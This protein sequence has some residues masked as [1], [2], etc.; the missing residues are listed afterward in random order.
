MAKR[1]RDRAVR[2]LEPVREPLVVVGL[3]AAGSSGRARGRRR[4]CAAEARPAP[5]GPPRASRAAPSERRRGSRCSG[6]TRGRETAPRARGRA[7]AGLAAHAACAPRSGRPIVEGALAHRAAHLPPV[8]RRV[9]ARAGHPEPPLVRILVTVGAGLEREPLVADEGRARHRRGLPG[10]GGRRR[11][12]GLAA[13]ALR[14]RD[15]RV[16][17]LERVR[18]AGVGEARRRLPA[19]LS[20]AAL[21]PEPSWPRCSSKWHAAHAVGAPSRVSRAGCFP[22]T[23]RTAGSRTR[24]RSWQRAHSTRRCL[25]RSS[26]PARA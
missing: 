24:R 8:H 16:L 23:S 10:G 12:L 5:S 17:P 11:R 14:A 9:T 7:V 19:V 3:E 18:R 1:A 26:N 6:R 4:R 2:A 20:V 22:R 25:P 15:R 21:A 13:V